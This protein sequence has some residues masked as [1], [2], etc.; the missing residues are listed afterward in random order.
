MTPSGLQNKRILAVTSDEF[1]KSDLA[2]VIARLPVSVE[3]TTREDIL[4]RMFAE[5]YDLVVIDR[6]TGTAELLEAIERRQEGAEAIA[7]SAC[8]LLRVSEEYLPAL[9]MPQRLTG[10]FLMTTAGRAELEKRVRFLLWPHEE[11][12]G[13]ECLIDGT[14]AIDTATY[15]VRAAGRPVDLAYQEYALLLF[16][17]THAG[18]AHSREELL[19]RVWGGQYYGGSRTV[20]VHVRRVRAKLDQ[21]S[22]ACL[23]TVRGMGYLWR[24]RS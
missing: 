17:V 6:G 7:R 4:R 9:C 16:L 13:D 12:D 1:F 14:L 5:S 23:E 3:W 19:R 24:K 2:T 11:P 15:Q 21:E 8:V 22:A 20:D 18:R 10:D